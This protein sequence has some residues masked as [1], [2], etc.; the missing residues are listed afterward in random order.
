MGR[1]NTLYVLS[2]SH[3]A[4]AARLMLERAEIEHDVVRLPPGFHSVLLR[5]R[6]FGGGTVPALRLDGR[7]VQGSSEI[8]R[9]IEAL[10]PPGILFPTD[11]VRRARVEEAERWGEEVLQPVPRRLFRWGVAGNADLRR[12]LA[13]I[14]RLPA[15]S[16][17]GILMK[18]VAAH[19]AKKSNGYDETVRADMERLPSM[20]DRVDA[21]I[22][23]GTIGGEA[24]NAADYQI[25]LSVRVMLVLE[26][27]RPAVEGRPA[28]ELAMRISPKYP[29]KAPPFLPEAWRPAAYSG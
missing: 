22:D 14:S 5:A 11:P 15:P 21:W 18:P 8:A 12:R 1:V 9:A 20:L 24:P 6:G 2:F 27:L 28:E 23:D 7:R 25:G 16:V 19:F 17:T 3:P 29:G 4:R 10:G 26:D 13:E